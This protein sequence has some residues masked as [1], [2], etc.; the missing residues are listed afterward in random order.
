MRHEMK[1]SMQQ[2]E[3]I[4]QSGKEQDYVLGLLQKFQLPLTR[5]NYLGLAYP[6][7]LPQ[8]WTAENELELPEQFRKVMA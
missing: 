8:D 5:E 6:E 4:P 7:G 3:S 2:A 1:S